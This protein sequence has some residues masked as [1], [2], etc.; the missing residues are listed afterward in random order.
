M[1]GA[2]GEGSPELRSALGS[3]SAVETK[4]SRT[5]ASERVAGDIAA[6]FWVRRIESQLSPIAEGGFAEDQRI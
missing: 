3:S 5:A 1:V 2:A 4:F 6:G